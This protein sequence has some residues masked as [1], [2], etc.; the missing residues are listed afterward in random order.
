MN[1]NTKQAE[2]QVKKAETASKKY[3][4]H[5]LA[6][7]APKIPFTNPNSKEK[8]RRRS[9]EENE[10]P[11]KTPIR[12]L[13][14]GCSVLVSG[15]MNEKQ[16]KWWNACLK[17]KL[18][19]IVIES[20]VPDVLLKCDSG[21]R[22]LKIVECMFGNKIENSPTL[23]LSEKWLKDCFTEQKVV[24]V[25]SDHLN[26]TIYDL[27][28]KI[29]DSNWSS[30]VTDA[31]VCIPMK[32]INYKSDFY[33]A[34]ESTFEFREVHNGIYVYYAD[35][36]YTHTMIPNNLIGFD[37]VKWLAVNTRNNESYVWIDWDDKS[38]FIHAGD[39]GKIM[40]I[41]L[42]QFVTVLLDSFEVMEQPLHGLAGTSVSSR[43]FN[44]N[45]M[46]FDEE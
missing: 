9:D 20:G 30:N 45:T 27:Y 42:K 35:P 11:K 18:F 40:E 8:K 15:L 26:T 25:S 10:R 2:T 24:D 32:L 19:D 21:H 5:Q 7:K 41:G 6:E 38:E 22:S 39:D 17:L 37:V 13:G 14:K 36:A 12:R 44:G 4:R 46:T 28:S 3:P 16:S 34:I 23:F 1:G 43:Y 29:V 33:H 31:I